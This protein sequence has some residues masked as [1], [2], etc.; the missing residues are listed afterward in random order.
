ML[1]W[2]NGYVPFPFTL[3]AAIAPPASLDSSTCWPNYN[4]NLLTLLQ[5]FSKMI[6]YWICTTQNCS[7]LGGSGVAIDYNSLKVTWIGSN[8]SDP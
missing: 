6:N 1:L 4:N 7:Y 2:P 8:V 3:T 5:N